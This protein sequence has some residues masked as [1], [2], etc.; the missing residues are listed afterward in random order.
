MRVLLNGINALSAGGSNVEKNIIY[1]FLA[2]FYSLL[3]QK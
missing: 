1:C 2:L 3:M